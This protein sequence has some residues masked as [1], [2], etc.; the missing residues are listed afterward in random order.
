M[1]NKLLVL[2]LVL[3]G[4][5]FSACSE[6]STEPPLVEEG[7]IALFSTPSGARIIIN[8]IIEGTTPDTITTEVGVIDILF[9]LENYVDT[10]V[11]VSVTTDNMGI[12]S[13]TLQPE[14]VK[15]GLIK[16]WETGNNSTVDQPSGID[17]SSGST[18][19][20]S[21]AD[22]LMADMYYTG[23]NFT[24]RSASYLGGNHRVTAFKEGAASDIDDGVDS[25][26]HDANWSDSMPDDVNGNYYF[27]YDAD[28]NYSKFRVVNTGG[29]ATW[30]DPKWVEVEWIYVKAPGATSF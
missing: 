30:N 15:Y 29:T 4:I 7:E 28:G 3:F 14:R 5:F 17:L 1:K 19:A 27:L 2:A 8:D 13:V 11:S 20:I 21:G 18:I 10:T 26:E 6:D 16:V 9:S 25:P 22:S 24:I 12:L 23:F